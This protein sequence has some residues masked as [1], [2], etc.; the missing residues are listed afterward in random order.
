MEIILWCFKTFSMFFSVTDYWNGEVAQFRSITTINPAQISPIFHCESAWAAD[1]KH[2][3]RQILEV[4]LR[5]PY[6]PTKYYCP[7]PCYGCG[8][9]LL[10]RMFCTLS[11]CCTYVQTTSSHC[12]LH[13][14]AFQLKMANKSN[15]TGFCAAPQKKLVVQVLLELRSYVL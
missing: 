1:R 11:L 4:E 7:P 14:L 3:E 13:M 10:T 2:E 5:E 6:Q 15:K 9:L 12:C 8:T